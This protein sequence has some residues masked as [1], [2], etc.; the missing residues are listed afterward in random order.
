M[1]RSVLPNVVVRDLKKGVKSE[2]TKL[3]TV[4]CYSEVVKKRGDCKK[5]QKDLVIWTVSGKGKLSFGIC[6]IIC[7]GKNDHKFT[8]NMMGSQ[9]IL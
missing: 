2:V 6:E 4:L 7:K 9:L 3:V 8:H 1:L 5:L